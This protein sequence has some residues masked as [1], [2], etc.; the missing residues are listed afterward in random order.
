MTCP[1]NDQVS[2]AGL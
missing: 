1:K 2:L